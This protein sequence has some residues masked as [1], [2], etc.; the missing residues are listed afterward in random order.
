MENKCIQDT[1]IYGERDF[2]GKWKWISAGKEILRMGK[3]QK[4]RRPI[5][6]T[7]LLFFV[8]YDVR[9]QSMCF[10]PKHIR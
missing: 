5:F 6:R 8:V 10:I 4:E 3:R 2:C 7:P 9:F 1:K